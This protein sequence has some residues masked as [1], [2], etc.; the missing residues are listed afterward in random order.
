MKEL[1]LVLQAET[2]AQTEGTATI[3]HFSTPLRWVRATIFLV[4]GVGLAAALIVVPILHLITT[5]ALPLAGLI[6]C[7]SVLRT[8]A[9]LADIQGRCPG[10]EASFSHNGGRAVFPMRID[11]PNCRRPISIAPAGEEHGQG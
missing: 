7:V 9:R 1:A 6:A 3:E 11:C 5:W 2:G 8:R 4:G 10:C